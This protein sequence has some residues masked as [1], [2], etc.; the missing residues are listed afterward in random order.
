MRSIEPILK[1]CAWLMIG[2]ILWL[3]QVEPAMGESVYYARYRIYSEN[4]MITKS[5]LEMLP[6]QD[7]YR[8]ERFQ[9]RKAVG[10]ASNRAEIDVESAAIHDAIGRVLLNC[11]LQSVHGRRT[12]VFSTSEDL[13]IL[14]YEGVLRYPIVTRPV[15]APQPDGMY[16]I[17][18]EIQFAPLAFPTQWSSR[19]LA[20]R[21]HR[22]VQNAG[23]FVYRIFTR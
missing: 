4:G 16:R 19:Y 21:I 6:A 9:R 12:M 18:A 8:M 1:R 3:L 14:D 11:G 15:E 20:H 17:E 10:V 23:T 22:A 13:V 7:E 2:G 5:L